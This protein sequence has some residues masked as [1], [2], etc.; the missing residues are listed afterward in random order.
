MSTEKQATIDT[1]VQNMTFGKALGAA[2]IVNETIDLAIPEGV[3][4]CSIRASVALT[5]N[6]GD[7]NSIKVEVSVTTPCLPSQV[8]TL[9]PVLEEYVK[10]RAVGL[11]PAKKVK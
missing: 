5:K 9:M 6:L 7:Y 11:M 4:V 1:S 8:E 10:E 3:P 2:L